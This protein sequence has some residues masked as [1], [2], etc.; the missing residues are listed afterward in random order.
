MR[1]AL[2][3]VLGCAPL[4]VLPLPAEWSEGS[5]V[6]AVRVG[7]DGR[8]IEAAALVPGLQA[9]GL[10]A[11]IGDRIVAFVVPPGAFVSETGAPIDPIGMEVRVGDAEVGCGRCIAESP[12]APDV[13]HSGEACPPPRFAEVRSFAVADGSLIPAEIDVESLRS[14][15][16]LSWP[17]ECACRAPDPAPGSDLALSLISGR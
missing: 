7:E 10:P 8:A 17:G 6:V 16:H 3:L 12:V 9:I 2:A 5:T 11:E 4:P 14:Q 1:A 15:V 13:V